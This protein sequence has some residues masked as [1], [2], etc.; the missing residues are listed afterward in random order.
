MF[1]YFVV[2]SDTCDLLSI[3]VIIIY[4]NSY[5]L[6]YGHLI[7]CVYGGLPFQTLIQSIC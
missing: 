7:K 2:E 6:T 4:A 5:I 3:V 1:Y